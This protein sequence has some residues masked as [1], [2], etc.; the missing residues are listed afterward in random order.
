MKELKMKILEVIRNDPEIQ[1]LKKK[2]KETFIQSFPL[3][4]HDQFMGIDDYKQQI[5]EALELGDYEKTFGSKKTQFG[6]YFKE[7]ERRGIHSRIDKEEFL[8]K[9]K[10]MGCTQEQIDIIV[11]DVEEKRIKWGLP[12]AW[13]ME[14]VKLPY[15]D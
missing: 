7:L 9:A 4:S 12:P 2:W 3:W 8:E 15:N 13:E 6:K 1:Q 11:K 14:L 10:E 5:R